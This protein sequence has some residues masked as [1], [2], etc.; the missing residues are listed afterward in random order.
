MPQTIK[1][2]MNCPGSIW[3]EKIS[4]KLMIYRLKSSLKFALAGTLSAFVPL[5]VTVHLH[6][7]SSSLKGA[8]SGA[9]QQSEEKFQGC[10]AATALQYHIQRSK[11]RVTLTW[12]EGSDLTQ[13]WDNQAACLPSVTLHI[14]I[15]KFIFILPSCW[16]L[17]WIGC[18]TV[19]TRCT[20]TV[21]DLVSQQW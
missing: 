4:N 6:R 14:L 20:F 21:L 13:S 10:S 2:T 3:L 18:N 12:G 9:H 11:T 8:V 1:S 7:A 17:L 19:Q 5:G 15:L 16:M